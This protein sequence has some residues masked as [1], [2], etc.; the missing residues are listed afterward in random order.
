MLCR[1]DAPDEYEKYD[2]DLMHLVERELF[3]R[4]PGLTVLPILRVP[5][6]QISSH[7]SR[8]VLSLKIN[9]WM[10]VVR[11]TQASGA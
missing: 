8:G 2:S 5:E 9:A 4:S 11:R 10:P 1:E 3:W 7:A 6:K